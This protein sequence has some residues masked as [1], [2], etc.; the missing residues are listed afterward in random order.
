VGGDN[1]SGWPE[2]PSSQ[3]FNGQI[4]ETAVYDKALTPEQ[5]NSHYQLATNPAPADTIVKV[6]A[7]EDAYA[8]AGAPSTN[9]GSSSSLAVRGTSAYESYLRF[10]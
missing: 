2:A 4:D 7:S 3:F 1:I 10:T 5:V 6:T 9:Y 8:N